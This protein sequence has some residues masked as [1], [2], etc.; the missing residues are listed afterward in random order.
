MEEFLARPPSSASTLPSTDQ[1]EDLSTRSRA[2][3][4]ALTSLIEATDDPLHLEE[5]LA[6]NDDLTSLLARVNARRSD[7]KKFKGLGIDIERAKL[8]EE[9]VSN[10]QIPAGQPVLEEEDEPVT[11]RVD[12]GKR[13]AE[14][15][16]EEPQPVL[17]PSVLLPGFDFD[18]AEP[19][20]DS[21]LEKVE[22]VVSPTDRCVL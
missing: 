7:L 3:L 10:G 1:P 20:G 19:G 12:K 13:R 21:L 22:S 11:P 18:D 15:E 9:P 16:P 2:A 8:S 6:L 5:M 4:Q 17:S 14:P